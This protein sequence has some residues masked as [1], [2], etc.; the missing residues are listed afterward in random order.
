[1]DHACRH[2]L[3]V[4]LLSVVSMLSIAGCSAV[5]KRTALHYSPPSAAPVRVAIAK[6]QT[7]ARTAK[8]SI[9]AAR[10]A[11]DAHAL[12]FALDA[13]DHA[14]DQ[15]TTSLLE[16][17]AKVGELEQKIEVQTSGLN[18]ANDEKN[19]ALDH[20][21]KLQRTLSDIVAQRNKLVALITVV[22]LGGAIF[23]FRRPLGALFGVPIPAI[24]LAG[25]LW[26]QAHP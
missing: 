24:V 7:Q 2:L 18:Q 15:L 21:A 4:V 22:A 5:P 20:A 26:P 11:P 8:Q 9:A 14:L 12:Q 16:A 1:M 25:F 13:S 19:A 6:A 17:T 3:S 23:L 10:I